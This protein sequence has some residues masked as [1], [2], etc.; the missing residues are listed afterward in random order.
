MPPAPGLLAPRLLVLG[1]PHQRL[2][3]AQRVGE[4]ADARWRH[5][6]RPGL[7]CGVARHEPVTQGV[8]YGMLS[9]V[10]C[11]LARRSDVRGA[12][13]RDTSCGLSRCC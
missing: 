1:L 12:I 7:G 5:A 2:A 11:V 6:P 13:L 4:R 3:G 10:A 9:P 8:V